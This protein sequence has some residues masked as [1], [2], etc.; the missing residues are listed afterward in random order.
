MNINWESCCGPHQLGARQDLGSIGR[1]VETRKIRTLHKHNV[2][3]NKPT[4]ENMENINYMFLS[5]T[6]LQPI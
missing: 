3:R 4:N 2:L 5:S 6:S 1:V